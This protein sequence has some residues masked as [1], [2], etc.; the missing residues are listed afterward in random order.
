MRRVLIDFQLVGWATNNEP[1]IGKNYSDIHY[2]GESVDLNTDSPDS[3]LASFCLEHGCDLMTCDRKAYVP[4]LEKRG[5]KSVQIS[6]Y[7]INESSG[8]QI[9]VV[10]PI[11]S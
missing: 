9:Y 10:R 8:Q 4:M 3:A 2:V 7:G 1:Q 6:A 5:V 11:T